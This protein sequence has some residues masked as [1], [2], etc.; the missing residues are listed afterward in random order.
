M[1][2]SALRAGHSI[3]IA[4]QQR[5]S[6]E[7]RPLKVEILECNGGE[8]HRMSADAVQCAVE[9][10]FGSDKVQSPGS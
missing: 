6:E 10:F 9:K 8:D 4:L 2:I 3:P 5:L 7:E 1:S